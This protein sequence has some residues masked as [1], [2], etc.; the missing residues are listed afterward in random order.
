MNGSVRARVCL[1]HDPPDAQKRRHFEF[2]LAPLRRK[3]QEFTLV[4][5]LDRFQ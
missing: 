5:G 4:Q 3:S 1:N 2:S